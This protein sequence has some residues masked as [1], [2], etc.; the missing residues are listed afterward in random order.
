MSD[1]DR[2]PDD[3][4]IKLVLGNRLRIAI[5]AAGTTAAAVAA[6][7]GLSKNMV[8]AVLDYKRMPSAAN[9]RKMA[10]FL[11]VRMAWLLP[12]L[13][14]ITP[15]VVSIHRRVREMFDTARATSRKELRKTVLASPDAVE[16][17][18]DQ[19]DLSD[20]PGVEVPIVGYVGANNEFYP[21]E[22]GGVLD[23]VTIPGPLPPNAVCG[24]AR[25]DS[26][27]PYYADGS[28]LVWSVRRYDVETFVGRLMVCH[29]A[30]ERVVVKVI[31]WGSKA[32]FYTLESANAP[33]MED[34]VVTCVSPLD[35]IRPK[36]L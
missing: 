4:L 6:G 27:L 15:E 29:L 7:T 36:G 19:A 11:D 26:G 22:D 1:V 20:M 12:A 16:L 13:D 9:L 21:A 5:E 14:S 23:T 33:A 31:R 32:G 10:D 24:I 17:V 2:I 8:G 34:V 35:W 3:E 28:L 30:D 25:G 18:A